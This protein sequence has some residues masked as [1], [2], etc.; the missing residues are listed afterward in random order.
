MKFHSNDVSDLDEQ[1]LESLQAIMNGLIDECNNL[2]GD[3]LAQDD[4]DEISRHYLH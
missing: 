3:L 2:L 1:K 4:S